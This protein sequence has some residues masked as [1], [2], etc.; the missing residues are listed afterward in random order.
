MDSCHLFNFLFGSKRA[1]NEISKRLA[2]LHRNN[3]AHKKH[4]NSQ[5]SDTNYSFGS[6]SAP[7]SP[8]KQLQNKIQNFSLKISKKS[9]EQTIS[10]TINEPIIAKTAID[11]PA[12]CEHIVHRAHLVSVSDDSLEDD[13]KSISL[14]KTNN[15]I[16]NGLTENISSIEI[17]SQKPVINIPDRASNE[18]VSENQKL[19][20]LNEYESVHRGNNLIDKQSTK[21]S[22][23]VLYED[24]LDCDNTILGETNFASATVYDLIEEPIPNEDKI[25][26]Q[27]RPSFQSKSFDEVK[28]T[29]TPKYNSNYDA[30]V[31]HVG[32]RKSSV[33]D[34]IGSF[35]SS[36]QDNMIS[37]RRLSQEQEV[38]KALANS[39]NK[40]AK[41]I[42]LVKPL[43]PKV[44]PK[45]EG[46]MSLGGQTNTINSVSNNESIFQNTEFLRL[47]FRFLD[48]LDRCKAAQ[49]CKKWRDILYNDPLYWADL[50]NVIDCTHLR[51]EHLIECIRNTL[52]STKVKQHLLSENNCS[53][54]LDQSELWKIQELCTKMTFK[55]Y[56][57]TLIGGNIF[58]LSIPNHT[59]TNESATNM[60][61]DSNQQPNS[62]ASKSSSIP[63]QISSTM[64]SLSLSSLISPLSESSRTDILK[65]KMYHSLGGRGFDALCLFGATNEDI[66]DLINKLPKYSFD[67]ITFAKLINCFITDAGLERFMC[68]FTKIRSLE[69]SGCNTISNSIDLSVLTRLSTLIITDCINIGDQLA[70]DLIPIFDKLDEFVLQSYHI[71]DAFMET[72]ASN[73]TVSQL[74][75]LDL[76]N[77]KE[78]TNQTLEVISRNFINLY[79]L[80]ISGSTRV[81]DTGIEILSEGL[82][83]LKRLDISWCSHLTDISLEYIACE[84]RDCLCEIVL[85]RNQLV[86]DIGI[87]YLTSMSNIS[88]VHLRWC[89]RVTDAGLRALLRKKT[90]RNL[91]IAGCNRITASSLMYVPNSNVT[92][93]ELTNCPA[94]SNELVNFLEMQKPDLAVIF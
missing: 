21:M 30:D 7:S 63:S 37:N 27:L 60:I 72:I 49:V 15:Q 56:N 22:Q 16:D 54:N 77:C 93:I 39:F 66:D 2:T 6:Q 48:P 9:E 80:S 69:L 94:A 91:S 43:P 35:E 4:S 53:N 89:I 11:N 90:I 87:N 83:K 88:L 20:L 79:S 31:S 12:Y 10:A 36:K 74:L 33:K 65:E 28:S 23:L 5:S 55:D 50:V 41:P 70:I 75:V 1:T 51:R 58:G 82:K 92:E 24:T 3:F 59:A 29:P 45:P 64:S 14:S 8:L 25:S 62:M 40:V 18:N 76:Q 84:L 81:N 68:K 46:I 42:T 57:Y 52:N 13:C 32:G 19:P 47:F 71:T 85:D 86:S 78:I 26:R 67:K 38:L 44:P 34:L 73:A 61:Q 17:K